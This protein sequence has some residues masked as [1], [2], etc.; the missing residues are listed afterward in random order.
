M[1]DE[2]RIVEQGTHAELLAL[3]GH[4]YRLTTAQAIAEAEG[5]VVEEEPQLAPPI[6]PTTKSLV[7]FESTV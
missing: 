4:Y 7:A 2:G 3:Q 1:V 6:A 5:E